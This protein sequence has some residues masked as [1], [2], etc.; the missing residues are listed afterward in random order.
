[1]V[2]YRATTSK[3]DPMVFSLSLLENRIVVRHDIPINRNHPATIISG[4]KF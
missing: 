3:Q 4:L 1:M 2:K